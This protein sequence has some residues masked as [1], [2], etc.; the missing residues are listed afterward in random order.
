LSMSALILL[1]AILA[2]PATGT[3]TLD[4]TNKGSV[5]V[6]SQAISAAV[7]VHSVAFWTQLILIV[8]TAGVAL[9]VK[10]SGDRVSKLVRA[11]T[12]ARI[13]EANLAAADAK[14]RAA[15]TLERAAT[16][17]KVAAA[18]QERA[19]KAEKELIELRE[20]IK[21]RTFTLDQR[22]HLVTSLKAIRLGGFEIW[23]QEGDPESNAFA[24]QFAGVFAE[25][26]WGYQ[27]EILP[28]PRAPKGVTVKV[29]DKHKLP[30][31]VA[32]F[33][34]AAREVQLDITLVEDRE[35]P[36]LDEHRSYLIVGRKPDVVQP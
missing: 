22:K 9:W 12:D 35:D 17:E 27:T 21:Q 34:E 8:L 33:L 31:Y 6:S 24:S 36:R 2:S 28:N 20:R 18:T 4:S 3:S 1:L 19:A 16:A 13:A 23:G 30:D 26:G 14:E 15:A 7:R 10:V 11:D 29:H 25:V 5:S 32:R